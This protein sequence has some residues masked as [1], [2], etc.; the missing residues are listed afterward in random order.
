MYFFYFFWYHS[1]VAEAFPEALV[2]DF[3][4][5]ELSWDWSAFAGDL[6]ASTLVGVL[7][8]DFFVAEVFPALTFLGVTDL[9]WMAGLLEADFLASDFWAEV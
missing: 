4:A 3:L 8:A 6:A 7:E 9:F 1:L 5:W 2:A